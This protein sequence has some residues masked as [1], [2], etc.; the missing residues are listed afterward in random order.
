MESAQGAS[1]VSLEILKVLREIN[2]KLDEKVFEPQQK[3]RNPEANQFSKRSPDQK[4]IRDG[5]GQVSDEETPSAPNDDQNDAV[6]P[7]TSSE[8]K[9]WIG[10]RGHNSLKRWRYP[11]LEPQK[12]EDPAL[13]ISALH[14]LLGDWWR[15]PNDG[16]LAL[17]FGIQR[18]HQCK[19]YTCSECSTYRFQRDT[20]ERFKRFSKHFSSNHP[21]WRRLCFVLDIHDKNALT[22]YRPGHSMIQHDS[23]CSSHWIDRSG[24]ETAPWSRYMYMTVFP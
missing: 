16:R 17:S 19:G 2:A 14:E 20:V 15:I 22:M 7:N 1:D 24:L 4:K 5:P 8:V 3:N 11:V 21:Q 23:E 12:F 6:V 10:P 13:S 9:R 18:T